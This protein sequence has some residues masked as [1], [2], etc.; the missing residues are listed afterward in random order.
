MFW[1]YFPNPNPSVPT[2]VWLQGGPGKLQHLEALDSAG[3][4]AGCFAGGPSTFAVFNEFGPFR[5]EPA[6]GGNFTVLDNP[7][8]VTQKYSVIFLDNPVGALQS[9]VA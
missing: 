7:Y 2:L 8:T 4:T 9:R 6:A 5:L 3:F 1:W